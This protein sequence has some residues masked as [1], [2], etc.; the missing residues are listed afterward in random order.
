MLIWILA[1]IL[2]G[3]TAA[4]G[5][6][7]GAIRAGV[8]LLGLVI[9]A[10]LAAPLGPYLKPLVPLVGLKNPIWPV[11]VPPLTVLLLVYFIFIGLS[12]FVHRKV[13]LYYKYKTEDRVRFAWERVNRAVGLW[14]G[15]IMGAAWLFLLGIG[16]YVLGYFAVQVTSDQTNTWYVRMLAQARQDMHDTGFEQAV[17]PFDPMTPR[18]YQATDILGLIYQNPILMG[19]ISQYPPFLLLADK[20]EFQEMGKDTEFNGLLL[21]RGDIMDIIRHPKMQAV[22]LNPDIVQD[23][24]NQDLKDFRAYL[25]TGVSPKYEE[26]KILGKW[27]LDPYATM[28]QERKKRP[29]LSSTE[30]RQLKRVM[31][32]I[33]PAVSFTATT[34]KKA[35]LKADINDRLRQIY[36]PPPPKV[37][38]QPQPANVP[39]STMAA[40]YRGMMQ[41]QPRVAVAPAPAPKT[42]DI[43]YTVLSAQGSWEHDGDKY[44]LKVQD[45]KGKSQTVEATAEDE[46]LTIYSPKLT[47]V[48]AKAE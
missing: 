16:I 26:E 30:M 47:L 27:K 22:M 38:A 17:A 15:M 42:N 39:S 20:S 18:Y 35:T 13:E 2:F 11:V 21:S 28:A 19:R 41:Q 32:E 40:R 12:F 4:C 10:A 25:E 44:Q 24:L 7:L 5:Y 3:I 45:E 43:P 31:L 33:M 14:V 8:A 9:G 36:A 46:R 6:K 48:F 29:D 1:L 34:D 23:L 37:V